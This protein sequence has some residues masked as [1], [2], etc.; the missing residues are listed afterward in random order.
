MP[1]QGFHE[2]VWALVRQVPPGRVATYGQIATLLGSPR[3]ARQVGYALAGAFRADVPVP[4]QRVIN[5]QGRISER[6]DFGRVQE[7]R[8]L[9]E[10]EGVEFDPTGRIDL[11]RFVWPFDGVDLADY[12]A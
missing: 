6:G 5:A 12:G 2:A 1:Q 4:W 8:A 9:L 3:L 11:T 10:S 7:Q